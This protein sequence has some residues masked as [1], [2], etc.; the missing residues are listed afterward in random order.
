MVPAVRPFTKSHRH[1]GELSEITLSGTMGRNQDNLLF[2]FP[3][4]G[5]A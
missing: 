2:L 5:V 3:W 1:C 4:R